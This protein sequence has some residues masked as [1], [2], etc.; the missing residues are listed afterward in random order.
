MRFNVTHFFSICTLLASLSVTMPA[1]AN[2]TLV[3]DADTGNVLHAE[4]ATRSWHPASLTK[5]MTAYLAFEA[6][7]EG[8]LKPLQYLKVSPAA[9]AQ[10]PS[11]MGFK[12]GSRITVEAAL[13]ALLTKS[14]NDMAVVLAEGI[15]GNTPAFVGKMNRKAQELGLNGTHFVNPNGMP[16]AEQV[17]TA[18]D[19]AILAQT[20]LYDFPQYEGFFRV[21]GLQIGTKIM[22]SFNALIG[23]YA[24]AQGMKTGFI[25]A[26]GFNLVASANRNGKRYIAVVLGEASGLKRAERAAQLL[27]DAF[28]GGIRGGGYSVQAL[29]NM[30]D[31]PANLKTTVCNPNRGQIASESE[32]S[33][34]NSAMLNTSEPSADMLGG[35]GI[36][37]VSGGMMANPSRLA[38]KPQQVNTLPIMVEKQGKKGPVTA[39]VD[40]GNGRPPI[41]DA[42]KAKPPT[43]VAKHQKLP[44]EGTVVKKFPAHP[45]LQGRILPHKPTKI[46]ASQAA[47]RL[48]P[49]QAE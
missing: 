14:A 20:I 41:D 29:R 2:P 13:H 1:H 19:M 6:L 42:P 7:S 16:A 30:N 18:R 34:D 27:D 36:V 32:E 5:L 45:G 26:S 8:K 44:I 21:Q 25:C 48:R 17:T 22:R 40:R 49:T 4:E 38:P 28:G 46:P 9:A 43:P 35:Q 12:P 11:K 37:S 31:A 24:G 3:I 15:S 47:P 23:R 10:K 39:F 33:F